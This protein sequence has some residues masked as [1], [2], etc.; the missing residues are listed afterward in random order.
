MRINHHKNKYKNNVL[1]YELKLCV[2]IYNINDFFDK[3]RK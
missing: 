1:K 3:M 2:G